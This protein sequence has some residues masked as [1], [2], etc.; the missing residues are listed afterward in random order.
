MVILIIRLYFRICDGYSASD[1][2]LFC[3]RIKCMG[4]A[5]AVEC[6]FPAFLI[7]MD[8]WFCSVLLLIKI[9]LFT[10]VDIYSCIAAYFQKSISLFVSLYLQN[11]IAAVCVYICVTYM[12]K[13]SVSD[14]DYSFSICICIQN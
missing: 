6:L 3:C 8:I 10:N 7:T 1:D 4:L 5:N 2:A 13:E 12:Y 11:V 14:Q 9:S